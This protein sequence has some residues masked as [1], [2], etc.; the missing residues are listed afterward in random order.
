MDEVEFDLTTTWPRPSYALIQL[1]TL[2]KKPIYEFETEKM[3]QL[4]S[5]ASPRDKGYTDCT[6]ANDL[7]H[8]SW[9]QSYKTCYTLGQ[10]YKYV[11]KLDNMLWLSEY[12]VRT[13][14]HYTLSIHRETF[15]IEAQS[16]T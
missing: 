9:G 10:I 15:L 5:N 11:L 4:Y 16:A 3:E 13:L 6:H 2:F 7:G 8:H 1:L 14:G 12:L